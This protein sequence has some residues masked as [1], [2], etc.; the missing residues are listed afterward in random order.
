MTSPTKMVWSPW[1]WAAITSQARNARQPSTMGCPLELSEYCTGSSPV[2]SCGSLAK[3]LAASFWARPRTL[4]AY[5]PLRRTSGKVL[6]V[7]LRQT[8][9]SGGSRESEVTEFCRHRL[10]R[11]VLPQRCNQGDPSGELPHRLSQIDASYHGHPIVE[12]RSSK[13]KIRGGPTTASGG[14]ELREGE[15]LQRGRGRRSRCT[16]PSSR[17]C[18]GSA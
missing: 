16:G 11:P 3:N 5:W 15:G 14:P 10:D 18:P 8:S 2:R 12:Q 13:T 7:W 9:T 1:S 17:R 4:I 6:Q